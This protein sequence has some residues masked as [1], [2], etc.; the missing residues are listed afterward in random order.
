M[1]LL[2][3]VRT[4]QTKPTHGVLMASEGQYQEDTMR[5]IR[6]EWAHQPEPGFVLLGYGLMLASSVLVLALVTWAL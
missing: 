1:W 6:S 3:M 5:I 2:R 4:D